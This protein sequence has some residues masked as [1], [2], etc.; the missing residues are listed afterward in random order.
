MTAVRRLVRPGASLV[1]AL[2]C[3]APLVA[4]APS[5]STQLAVE[6][7]AATITGDDVRRRIG[8]IAADSMRGRYTPS[9]ELNE[10][11]EWVAS[12]FRSIGLQPGG[13]GGSFL[14]RYPIRALALNPA[15]SKARFGPTDLHFGRDVAPAYS[16]ILP[17]T[18]LEGSLL[19]V[20]GTRLETV[21]PEGVVVTGTHVLVVPPRG[22]DLHEAAV[23]AVVRT[24]LAAEPLAVWIASDHGNAAWAAAANKELRRQHTFVGDPEE[25]AALVVRDGIVRPVLAALGMDLAALRSRGGEAVRWDDARSVSVA[26]EVAVQVLIDTGAPNVVGILPGSDLALR[27]EYVVFS[28]HIDHVGVGTPDASG[29]SIYNGADDDASGTVT[30]VELAE[31]FASLEPRPR[32]SLLFLTVSGEERGLWGS[33]WFVNH[34]PVP[35][36]G[37]VANLNI[38]MVGRNWSDTIVAIGREHSDLGETLAYVNAQHPELGMTAIGDLWPAERFYMRSDHYRFARRGVPILFFF[39]GTHPDYHEPSDEVGK[40]DADKTARVGRLIFHLGLEVANRTARPAWYPASRRAI[41][42]G[43]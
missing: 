39:N 15:E 25:L 29:D 35:L 14:Q 32:R 38:D 10:T 31:A 1:T 27:D 22:A 33:G 24:V 43:G 19:V 2:L 30:V 23:V 41:V 12:E 20:S 18:H 8:V 9:P 21:L 4:Q 11:A 28:A 3:A 26:L 16:A 42:G 6:R 7:A 37:M 13:D 17:S 36:E 34:P 40:I 5:L